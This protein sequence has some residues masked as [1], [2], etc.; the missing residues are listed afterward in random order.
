[1]GD[2]YPGTL[3]ALGMVAAIHHARRTGLGQFLDV[4]MYDSVTFLCETLVANYGFAGRV[5][6][7][8]G[9]GHPNLCPFDV[10]EAADGGIAIAAP[11]PK[12]WEALC[13][14][15]AREDL[16]A[17]PRS[18]D[19][20]ARVA[21]RPFVTE[22]MLGWTRAHTRAQITAVLGGKVPCGPVNTA[23]DL[24]AD[25]HLAARGMIKSIAVPGDN[26]DGAVV[27]NPIHF[28][29]TPARDPD[30]APRLGEHAAG[31]LAQFGIDRRI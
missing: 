9:S 18:R 24:F 8:R 23:E 29:A 28:T 15:M 17:D 19:L 3:L 4:A 27:A 11:G 16:L 31:I 14:A 7:P 2:I 10:Y 21:N 12:H 22:A 6:G 30:P 13:I 20:K 26:P 1:V 25:P 5:L